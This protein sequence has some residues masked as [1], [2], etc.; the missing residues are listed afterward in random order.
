M[1]DPHWDPFEILEQLHVAS[2]S[3]EQEI[4][5]IK[6]HI[7]IQAQL[8]EMIASQVKHLTNAVVGLQSVN[9]ILNE[10]L[11]RLEP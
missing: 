6:A 4:N 5:E 10:R 1:L 3:A 7:Q 2:M 8:M 9:K 11:I